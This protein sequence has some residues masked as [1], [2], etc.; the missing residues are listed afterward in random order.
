MIHGTRHLCLSPDELREV[1]RGVVGAVLGR[2]GLVQLDLLVP[3]KIG[4][5]ASY[6]NKYWKHHKAVTFQ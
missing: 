4:E 2:L 5:A 3:D 1:A 6:I